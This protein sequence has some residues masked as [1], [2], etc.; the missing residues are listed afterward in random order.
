MINYFYDRVNIKVLGVFL[1]LFMV[2]CTQ[3]S[4]PVNDTQSDEQ[5]T[6]TTLNKTTFPAQGTASTLDFGTWNLEWFGDTE[7]GPSDEQLQLEN[8]Q[9]II[10]GL[11]MDLWSV[12]EVTGETH[13][14]NLVSQLSGYDGLLANDP[15]VTD[16]PEYYSDFDNNEMK[17]GLIFKTDVITVNSAKV[18]LKEYDNEFAGRPP[19][20]VQLSAT[21]DGATENLVVI[22]L[23][24]KAGSRG[25]AFE[26]RLAGSEAMKT[27]LDNTWPDAHVM[28]IGD[29][30]DDVDQS[31]Q[32]PNDSPYK[33]FV[34]DAASYVFPTKELSDSG[35][36]ST[37]YY[38][39]MIDHHLSS[40]ELIAT[41]EDGTVQVFPADQYLEDYD[42]TT[43]DHY[44]VLSS[45]SFS[46][47]GGDDGGDDETNNSPIASYTFTCTELT[48]DFDG[49]GSYDS[50]G[51]V[52]NYSWDLG[53]G[54]TASGETVTHSYSTGGTYTVSL[55]ITD[56][57]GATDTDSQNISVTDGQ[58]E[59]ITLSVS[60]YKVQGQQKADLS[61]SGTSSSE[62]DILRDGTIIATVADNGAYIDDI[63]SRGGGSYTY[64]VCEANT[65]SCSNEA[66]VT[67]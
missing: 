14:N 15:S 67:F 58:A 57:A 48:C 60:G 20:E 37:V 23:H 33:N 55:T 1:A 28:V 6:V 34:D 30:N 36:S 40:N 59:D 52:A 24:A 16:G 39:D 2:S 42:Q 47:G 26:R 19:V 61:W 13:F 49:S 50:D 54:N 35:I 3:E 7:N 27:Y 53:D 9:F 25:D 22:L 43:S 11:D 44:P 62:V 4:I 38:S 65:E 8:V 51:S 64:Q 17:V 31:I 21:L 41:Y 32:K 63:N 45:Y 66:S 12:Q 29:F 56:D 18:I 5:V 10:S 46:D